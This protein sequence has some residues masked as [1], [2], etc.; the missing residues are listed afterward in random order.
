M[1]RPPKQ[2]ENVRVVDVAGFDVSPCG[3]THVAHTSQ[4]GLVRVVSTEKYKGGTRV[5]FHAGI[6]AREHLFAEDDALRAL[7]RTLVTPIDGVVAGVER[8]RAELTASRGES[9]RLRGVLASR[10]AESAVRSGEKR[11][12]IVL[13]DGGVEL[14]Q[15][16]AT[17]LTKEGD[18][19]AIVAMRTDEGTHVVVARGPTATDDAGALVKRITAAA[20]GKGGGR[21]ERAEGRLPAG[22]DLETV[23]RAQITS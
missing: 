4:I 7:A 2:S 19:L 15:K 17:E 13:D 9:G 8:L 18:R 6:R 5:S 10:I 16:I 21:P 22:A 1:R 14:A 12:V 20:G 3:G 23:L 11:V